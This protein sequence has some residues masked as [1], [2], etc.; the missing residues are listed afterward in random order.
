MSISPQSFRELKLESMTD[1]LMAQPAQQ[2][3]SFPVLPSVRNQKPL[4]PYQSNIKT[5]ILRHNKIGDLRVF[6]RWH[7]LKGSAIMY[8]TAREVS[9]QPTSMQM[10]VRLGGLA[11]QDMSQGSSPLLD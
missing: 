10:Q 4:S 11:L 2:R 7:S 9:E 5:S 8:D 3:P 1:T 6:G